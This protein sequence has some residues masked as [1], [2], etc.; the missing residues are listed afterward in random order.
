MIQLSKPGILKLKITN[1]ININL[2]RFQFHKN[3]QTIYLFRLKYI[4]IFLIKRLLERARKRNRA[5]VA[6]HY[7]L[8]HTY[9]LLFY[10]C[11]RWFYFYLY[12]S[13]CFS[14]SLSVD[15]KLKVNKMIRYGIEYNCSEKV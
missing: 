13:F 4:L 10:Y 9:F 8:N 1:E 15:F 3:K 5:Q 7:L 6:I 11:F 2:S 12:R 14:L